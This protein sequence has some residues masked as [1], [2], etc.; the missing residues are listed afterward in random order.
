MK[1][2]WYIYEEREAEKWEKREYVHT[3]T[4]THLLIRSFFAC[5][6]FSRISRD[7]T[8]AERVRVAREMALDVAIRAEHNFSDGFDSA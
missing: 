3:Y 8:N 6:I 1:N 2:I 4:H 7:V 5:H